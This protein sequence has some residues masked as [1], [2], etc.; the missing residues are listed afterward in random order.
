VKNEDYGTVI[1]KFDSGMVGN[2]TVSQVSSGHKNDLFIEID[3]CKKS[4]S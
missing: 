1:L 4:F 2:F 3:G